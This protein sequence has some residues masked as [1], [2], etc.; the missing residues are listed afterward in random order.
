L[1]TH[2]FREVFEFAADV[3]VLRRGKLVARGPVG[4]FDR[5]RLAEVMVGSERIAKPV[6][7]S[8]QKPGDIRLEVRNLAADNDRGSPA[9]AGVS[10]L[11]RAGEILGVAGVSGNG[12]RELVEVLAGQ[13]DPSTGS[14]HIHGEPYGSSRAEIRRHKFYLL[15]EEPLQNACARDMS[16]AENLAIRDFD[17][18]PKAVGGWLLNRGAI[19]REAIRLIER[20]NIRTRSPD[21]PVAELSGG[22]V[23]RTVLARELSHEVEVLVAAN[24]CVGLDVGA[25]SEI[26]GQLIAARNK[27]AAVLLVSEDLDELTM[28][29]DRLV[30]IFEGCLVYEA[31]ADAFETRTIGRHMAGA[32]AAA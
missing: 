13:R 22:N 21:A 30:V 17:R 12:Q 29:A 7:R 6:D 4:E 32:G 2:K 18:P 19:R 25:I 5:A 24:P 20:Y 28:L 9:V 27:G 23:Q 3:S 26:H 15:P 16:V 31:T 1:I 8:P 14:I 10:F 11:V